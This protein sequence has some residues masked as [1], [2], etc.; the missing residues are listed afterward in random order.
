MLRRREALGAAFGARLA[1]T[2]LLA[3]GLAAWPGPAGAAPADIGFRI[4]RRGSQIGTHIVR[5][6]DALGGIEARSEVRVLVQLIGITVYRYVHDTVETWRGDRLFALSSTSERNGTRGF[7]EVRSEGGQLLLR[8][9]ATPVETRLPPNAAP[10]TWWRAAT[11]LTDT[12]VFDPRQG[13]AVSPTLRRSRAP[14]GGTRVVLVGG[15]G[16]EIVYDATG[17]WV[18]FGT[19][20]EDGSTVQFE[21]M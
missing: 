8:G 13:E 9:A 14:G 18:G 2:P 15:E 20:G 12:P 1:A 16:A 4:M 6:R 17:A 10:L 21:R 19:T 5:F 11:L 7:C 3:A